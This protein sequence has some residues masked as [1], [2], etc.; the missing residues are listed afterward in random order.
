MKHLNMRKLKHKNN[1]IIRIEDEETCNM[2]FTSTCF[3][4][5]LNRLYIVILLGALKT[6]KFLVSE[7]SRKQS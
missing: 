4:A 3:G 6:L 1:K 5:L 2:F 7:H